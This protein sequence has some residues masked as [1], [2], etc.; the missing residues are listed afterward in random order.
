MWCV[1]KGEVEE[2]KTKTAPGMLAMWREQRERV[3]Q[4][5]RRGASC[6]R[7]RCANSVGGGNRAPALV[8]TSPAL[9]RTNTSDVYKHAQTN[10]LIRH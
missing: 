2:R 7:G 3:W 1:V 5:K 8:S 9:W 10:I 4:K 6:S